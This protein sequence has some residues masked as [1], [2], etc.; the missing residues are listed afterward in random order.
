MKRR[1]FLQAFAATALC[2]VPPHLLASPRFEMNPFTLGVASG[3]PSASGVCLWTRLAPVPLAPD[4]GMPERTV[5]VRWEVAEDAGFRTLAAQGTTWATPDWAH[6]VHVEP[7]TLRP[8]RVYWYRFHAGDATS[9]IGRTQTTPAE[10]ADVQ[11]VSFAFLSCQHYEQGYYGAY[12]HLAANP[13][14]LVLHLG[15]Y[16]YESSWSARPVRRHAGPEPVTLADYRARHAQYKTDPLLQAAHAVAPWALVWDDHEVENDYA[17]DRSENL[18]DPAWFLLR[19]AAAYKAWYEHMP[20]RR[21]MVPAGPALQ[22]FGRLSYGNLAQFH[23]LDDRQYRSPQPCPKPGRGGGN[24]VEACKARLELAA[25]LLGARQEAWLDAGLA[26]SNARWNVLA[27]QTLMAQSDTKAG[28]GE[29]FYTDGWDGYPAA[30]ERLISRLAESKVANPVVI[31]GDVHAFWVADL[32]QDF[33]RPD[34]PTIA[35]EFVGGSVTSQSPP[36]IALQTAK[37][38][39]PHIRFVT[40]VPR[41]YARATLTPSHMATTFIAVNDVRDPQ[42]GASPLGR[43]VVEDGKPGA[44]ED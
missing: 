22:L 5:E 10:G 42:S 26:A 28:E 12:R 29:R 1:T 3:Y 9:P 41:G 19:R 40:G 2:G 32:K 16:I 25:T 38:E 30:R 18:D 17:N 13:P 37:Q 27:Q 14:D 43:W 11:S 24:R 4:G 6:S 35:T 23:L 15:D 44:V 31:G 7:N 21:T 33:A 20:A 36:E 8:G 39:G 34:S